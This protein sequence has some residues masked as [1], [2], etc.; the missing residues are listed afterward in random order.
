ML[1]QLR[2]SIHQ[3]NTNLAFCIRNQSYSYADLLFYV[4][5]IRKMLRDDC[6]AVHFIGLAGYDDIETYA[7]I[8]AIWAEG[9]AFVPLS[10]ASPV[11]RNFEVLR[12]VGTNYALSSRS[13][14]DSFLFGA[15][16]QVTKD[17]K[18]K[19][20]SSV[21]LSN[22][23]AD[24]IMCMIFTSGSTGVPKGVPYTFRNINCTLNAFFSLGYDLSQKD[25]FLQMFELTFD[26]SLLSYLPAWC[27]GASVFPI[28][29]KQV[30][31]LGAYQV[32][33]QHD[34][35][36][37][38]MVPS[39]LQFLKPYF[40]Q[41]KLPHLRYCLLGGEPLYVELATAW[42]KAVPHT[43]VVNISGPCET[44]MACVG[45]NLNSD[46]SKNKSHRKVLAFGYPWKNTKVLIVDEHNNK[47]KRGDEGELCFAGNN[48]MEGYWQMPDKNAEL[49]FEKRIDGKDYRFYKSG[50]L[51]FQD[52][53]GTLYSCGRKDQQYKIQGY[54]V[55]L[56]DV[57]RHARDVLEKQ[58]VAATVIQNEKGILEIHLFVEGKTI[59]S[60]AIQAHLKQWLPV[61]MLPKKIHA[62]DRLPLT[63]SGKLDR[64]RLKDFID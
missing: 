56:G 51:A 37:A 49:F 33:Q 3:E 22:W 53:E 60:E 2:N 23:R 34:I 30:K 15:K 35:T 38:A 52:E 46:M 55:E 47:V 42:L 19:E 9:Y 39:T 57:E 31:Y 14:T 20:G 6:P 5:G 36:F 64:K 8:L 16:V 62:L 11:E 45:Y 26:M 63:L 18:S 10:T 61:Y 43:Q 7:S 12:Q 48:V 58:N 44:T 28:D 24:H 50:D 4:N 59:D 27:I 29:H 40:K 32:L 41:V 1:Q 25:R 21:D 54:K 17:L 13:D